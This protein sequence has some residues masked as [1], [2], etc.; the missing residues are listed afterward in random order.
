MAYFVVFVQAGSDKLIDDDVR[1]MI[2]VLFYWLMASPG[3]QAP[4]S[5]A[6]KFL[7]SHNSNYRKILKSLGGI[8]KLL[9]YTA[10]IELLVEHAAGGNNF[11][12]VVGESNTPLFNLDHLGGKYAI[13]QISFIP[14]D[15]DAY[16]ILLYDRKCK[17]SSW[18]KPLKPVTVDGQ[19]QVRLI[20]P[21]LIKCAI[22]LDNDKISHNGMQTQENLQQLLVYLSLKLVIFLALIAVSWFLKAIYLLCSFVIE[23]LL[24]REGGV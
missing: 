18:D 14:N 24:L 20:P 6:C 15:D 8:R 9:Y 1:D 22:P 16:E 5:E 2:T 23:K 11:V 4:T 21:N 3:K 17:K 12:R 19:K 7:Y 13:G 10:S